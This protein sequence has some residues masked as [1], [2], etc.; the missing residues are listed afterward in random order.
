[1]SLSGTIKPITQRVLPRDRL[2]G[3]SKSYRPTN[4]SSDFEQ[5]HFRYER[6]PV[7]EVLSVV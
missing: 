5:G 2:N 1:M 6:V 3:H 4:R 7:S